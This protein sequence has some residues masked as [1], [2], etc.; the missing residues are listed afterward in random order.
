[1]GTNAKVHFE[2][3]QRTWGPGHDRLVDGVPYPTNGIGY[4]DP[5]GFQCIW[6]AR[7]GVPGGPGILLYYPGGTQGA[8]LRGHDP[9]GVP[10]PSDIRTVLARVDGLFPGTSAAYTGRAIQSF[11]AAEPWH[12]GAYSYWGSGNYTSFAGAEGLQEGRIHF[13]GEATSQEYQGYINGAVETGERVAR[14]IKSQV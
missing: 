13:A 5:D 1:M 14:E 3:T 2:L 4:S 11:W 6:D 9:F 8:S 7:P 12:H 10:N